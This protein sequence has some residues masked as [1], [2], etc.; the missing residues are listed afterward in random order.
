MANTEKAQIAQLGDRVAALEATL[1][2][3]EERLTPPAPKAPGTVLPPKWVGSGD[4]NTGINYA[5]PPTGNVTAS[6]GIAGVT[7][8]A[9]GNWRDPFNIL[10][11]A[12]GEIVTPAS[13]APRPIG[14]ERDLQHQ[15][16]IE[17]LDDII[18]RKFSGDKE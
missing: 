15:R 3:I 14:P 2:R 9:A 10:R 17:L 13:R 12:A 16:S 7:P 8:D 18:E 6:F 1:R 11:N 5:G 4:P